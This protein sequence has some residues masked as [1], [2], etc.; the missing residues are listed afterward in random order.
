MLLKHFCEIGIQRICKMVIYTSSPI[1]IAV[2]DNEE[3]VWLITIEQGMLFTT[4]NVREL[5]HCL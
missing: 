3:Y 4:S 2:L 5:N 1:R